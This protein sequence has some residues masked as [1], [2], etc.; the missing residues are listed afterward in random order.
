MPVL[1]TGLFILILSFAFVFTFVAFKV[2]AKTTK[3]MLHIVA[4]ALFLGLGGFMGAGYEVSATTNETLD[5]AIS[6][7][8]DGSLITFTANTTKNNILL[9]GGEDSYYI[10]YLFLGLAVLNLFMFVRDVW[11]AV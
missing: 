10:T 1:E 6:N 9:P 8:S 3:G 2:L 7:A 11:G 4:M 5:T